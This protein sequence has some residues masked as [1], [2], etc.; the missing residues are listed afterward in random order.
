MTSAT[1][2]K[3]PTSKSR[4]NTEADSSQGTTSPEPTRYAVSEAERLMRIA[5]A[6]YFRAERRGF[7]PG[8]ELDD[9]LAAEKEFDSQAKDE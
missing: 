9:W 5:Q 7:E 4:M 2:Q 8:C 1:L 6:A 3:R